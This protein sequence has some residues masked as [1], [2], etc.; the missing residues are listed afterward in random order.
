[1]KIAWMVLLGLTACSVTPS[2]APPTLQALRGTQVPDGPN[3]RLALAISPQVCGRDDHSIIYVPS[4]GAARI[5]ITAGT[6]WGVTGAYAQA[7][8]GALTVPPGSYQLWG[9]AVGPPS[10]LGS[11]L[12]LSWPGGP[13]LI[14]GRMQTTPFWQ[15]YGHIQ[16]QGTA[17]LAL[18][19]HGVPNLQLRWYPVSATSSL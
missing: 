13:S 2:I 10:S 1:M 5:L 9:A 6:A 16:V 15:S 12:S 17:T 18:I 11:Q 8:A 4:S 7:G 14:F 3:Y 19:N